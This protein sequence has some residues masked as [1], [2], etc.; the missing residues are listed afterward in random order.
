MV[1]GW[2]AISLTGCLSV[3]Q[4]ALTPADA[5]FLVAVSNAVYMGDACTDGSPRGIIRMTNGCYTTISDPS[6]EATRV[7]YSI[8]K[9]VLGDLNHDGVPDAA[10]VVLVEPLGGTGRW[11]DLYA[12]INSHAQA[13]P[14]VPVFL[15]DRIG[16]ISVENL[17][18]WI[19]VEFYCHYPDEGL[20]LPPLHKTFRSFRFERGELYE[21]K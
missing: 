18:R 1:A 12:V 16:I 2:C 8:Q 11:Y 4:V 15:G 7:N 9:V 21:R 20:Q 6:S 10:V 19:V 13:V 14:T 3:R 5:R 17:S